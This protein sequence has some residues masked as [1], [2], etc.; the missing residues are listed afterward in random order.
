MCCEEAGWRHGAPVQRRGDPSA[1]GSVGGADGGAT[2]GSLSQVPQHHGLLVNLPL[3]DHRHSLLPSRLQSLPRPISVCCICVIDKIVHL[4]TSEPILKV[5]RQPD[6]THS[7]LTSAPPRLS[8]SCL[9]IA[10]LLLHCHP[11]PRHCCGLTWG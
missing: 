8:P 11:H 9:C 10:P 2:G 4:K 7:L 6:R 1:A 3:P 5:S